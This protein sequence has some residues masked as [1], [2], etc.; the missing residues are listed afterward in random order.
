MFCLLLPLQVRA[1][2][3]VIDPVMSPTG[4][5]AGFVASFSMI[6]VSE[7]GDRTFFIVAILAMNN[8]RMEGPYALIP[9]AQQQSERGMEMAESHHSQSG[10]SSLLSRPSYPCTYVRLCRCGASVCFASPV[11]AAAMASAVLMTVLSVAM[12]AALPAMLDTQITHYMVTAL[13]FFFGAKLLWD[14]WGMEGGG[15]LEDELEEVEEELKTKE[16]EESVGLTAGGAAANSTIELA[17]VGGS[18]PTGLMSGSGSSSPAA[19]A[20]KLSLTARQFGMT[21]TKFF[22]RFFSKVFLTCFSMTFLAEW[23]DRSQIAT[24][25]LAAQKDALGVTAGGIIGHALCTGVAVLGGRLLATRVS[26]RTISIIGG[27]LFLGF[28]LHSVYFGAED[29]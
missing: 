10:V 11:F 16:L 15:D 24:I 21:C 2:T 12:G 8:N 27:V 26:E 28:G 9:S 7:F 23:G 25:A 4:F 6:L 22:R 29:D 20:A 13:F 5:I 17:N 1:D 3:I 19:A 18:A 14:A